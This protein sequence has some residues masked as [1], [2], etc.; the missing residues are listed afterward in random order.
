MVL[1]VVPTTLV[2]LALL[3][4]FLLTPHPPK[5]PA[6]CASPEALRTYFG[7]LADHET[8]PALEATVSRDGR[9]VFAEAFGSID[10]RRS[11]PNSTDAVYHYWSVTKLFTAT[12]IMQLTEDG[13]LRLDEPVTKYLPGFV[14][15]YRHRLAPITIRQLLSHSSGMQDL[16]PGD[17]V[18]WIHHLQDPP[19]RQPTLIEKRMSTYRRL[20]AAPGTRSAYSNAGYIVLSAIIE[21]AS[22]HSY[23]EFVRAR[24]L[25]P[26]GMTSTDF[27]IAGTCSHARF[28]EPTLC[29]TY[30][31]RCW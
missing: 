2:V 28:P 15:S 26:L 19:M 9:T 29:S 31:L 27:G 14:T 8:P 4:L 30:S 18:G 12:A 11:V 17:L 23:E 21:R 10:S 1:L 5:A 22:G 16:K 3:S 24:I 25:R 6:D 20:V 13:K 7:T